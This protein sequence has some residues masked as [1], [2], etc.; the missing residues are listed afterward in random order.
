MQYIISNITIYHFI[1]WFFLIFHSLLILFVLFGWIRKSLRLYHLILMVL[2]LGSWTVL[3]YLLYGSLGYCP[4]TDW[5]FWALRELGYTG[6]PASYVS[7]L[8]QRILNLELSQTFIDI[9]TE[10]LGVVTFV[11][12]LVLNTRDFLNKRRQKGSEPVA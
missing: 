1:D 5:H 10:G 9:L 4:F 11:L 6:L 12:S 8:F 3:S 7:Y 2:T